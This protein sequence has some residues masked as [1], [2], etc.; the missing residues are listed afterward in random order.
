[1]LGA[2]HRVVTGLVPETA[3]RLAASA[4]YV[5]ELAGGAGDVPAALAE[6]DQACSRGIAFLLAGNSKIWLLTDPDPRQLQ[7][8]VP[9]H[10][11]ELWQR[12]PAAVL[13][14][15][16]VRP[17]LGGRGRRPQRA[18]NPRCG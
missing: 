12:V 10:P 9:D 16:A 14:G 13:Q 2:I 1:M 17:D 11:V 6:L 3:A 8:A 7:A 15:S 4:F 18:G 5:R